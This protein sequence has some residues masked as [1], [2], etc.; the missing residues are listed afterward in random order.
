MI[1]P[2]PFEGDSPFEVLQAFTDCDGLKDAEW[3]RKTKP[4]S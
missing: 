1:P 2:V 3:N 4:V